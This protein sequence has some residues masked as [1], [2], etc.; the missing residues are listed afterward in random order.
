MQ[1]Q[2]DKIEKAHSKLDSELSG[3]SS[4]L[5]ALSGIDG[6]SF[7]AQIMPGDGLC[8]NVEYEGDE[9]YTA[10]DMAVIPACDLIDTLPLKSFNDIP[11]GI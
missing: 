7:R 4:M 1:K 8:F 2:I 11:V 5:T 10:D 9:G 3:L 6:L